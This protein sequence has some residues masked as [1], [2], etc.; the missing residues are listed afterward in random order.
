MKYSGK[1]K[2]KLD[3]EQRT[4]HL[5]LDRLRTL[6]PNALALVLAAKLDPGGFGQVVPGDLGSPDVSRYH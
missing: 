6:K 4:R 1:R 2:K 5:P 3:P